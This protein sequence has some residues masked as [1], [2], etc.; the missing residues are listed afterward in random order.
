MARRLAILVLAGGLFGV[1]SPAVQGAA[2]KGAS[3]S[4]EPS[5]VPSRAGE[6]GSVG[7]LAPSAAPSPAGDAADGARAWVLRIDA[8]PG[9]VLRLAD[10]AARGGDAPT[11]VAAPAV[12][13]DTA[14]VRA[15][16]DPARPDDRAVATPLAWSDPSGSLTLEG[17]AAEAQASRTAATAR[18]GFGTAGGTGFPMANRLFTWEQQERLLAQMA[19]INDA[20]FTPLNA[21]IAALAPLLTAAGVAAPRFEPASPVGFVDVGTGRLAAASAEVAGSGDYGSGRAEA[22]L[23]R[24]R[25][26]GGFVDAAGASAEA[27]AERS[28]GE[29]QR[30]ARVW[31][32]GLTV[33]GV[34][35][36]AES[37]RLRVAAND[38]VSRA[39]VQPALDL[40]LAT[41]REHG[42]DLRVGATSEGPAGA[43]A[44]ALELAVTAASGNV[45][46]S[47][48]AAAASAPA[49]F[50]PAGRDGA[51]T[52]DP[53]TPGL[54]GPGGDSGPV[55]APPVAA[56]PVS[57]P[58]VSGS[59]T[60]D[61]EPPWIVDPGDTA[62]PSDGNAVGPDGAAGTAP[63][64]AAEMPLATGASPTP[65]ARR[66]FQSAATARSLRAV[67]LLLAVA[68]AAGAL[69]L[70]ALV[71]P[72]VTR[73]GARRRQPTRRQSGRRQQ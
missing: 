72:A 41:L 15:V 31:F 63:S 28:A 38:V 6:A 60:P 61:D 71:A 32:A 64:P 30:R 19:A 7:P 48:G 62:Q 67:Y 73:S 47:I 13:G 68:A 58:P 9:P 21:R 11:A 69:A 27:V 46:V 25:L 43:R 29:E 26:L 57:A 12:V 59:G 34:P 40:L 10:V 44:A 22:M 56:P 24:V 18:A 14:P 36:V 53:S 8:S 49:G 16:A 3:V 4:P 33:A 2:G 51:A 37:G 23:D 39:V 20:V 50:L 65:A 66:L 42:V 5:A 52:G 35:V 1:S 70:P 45:V 17:G 54:R 55:V